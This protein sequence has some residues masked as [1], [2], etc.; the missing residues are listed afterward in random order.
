M[1]LQLPERGKRLSGV[2]ESGRSSFPRLGVFFLSCTLASLLNTVKSK[3][4]SFSKYVD[5]FIKLVSLN[6]LSQV[7]FDTTPHLN[8]R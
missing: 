8:V 1:S 6:T 7:L 5:K 3:G 4:V 2:T